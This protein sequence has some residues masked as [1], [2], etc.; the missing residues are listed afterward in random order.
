MSAAPNTVP[1]RYYDGRTPVPV[2]V[3][4]IWSGATVTL[5]GANI[6]QTYPVEGMRVSP[7]VGGADR[8]VALPDGAQL[9]CPDHPLLDRF[10]QEG[11]TEG[12]VAWLEQ[13]WQVALAGVVVMLA[14]LALGYFY[15]L[16]AAAERIAARVPV[17]YE[18]KL[19]EHALAWLDQHQL[20][21]PSRLEPST[22]QQLS[23]GFAELS[24]D[25][26]AAAHYRLLFRDAPAIGPNALAFPGGIIVITDEMIDLAESAGEVYA[27]LAHE[28]GHL[29]RR[30]TL[31]HILQNSITAAVAATLTAD[32]SSLTLAASGVP[33]MLV[34][35]KYSREF[36]TEADDFAFDLLKRHDLSP[37]H[38]ANL[39]ERLSA[40]PDA[41]FERRASFL[42]THPVTADR[43]ARA[44]AAAKN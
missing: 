2:P 38:F 5:M 33:V 8:F 24:R 13:R 40:K 14:G 3:T 32:A 18:K 19:G 27:V 11:R 41:Q 9:Q 29:Q 21:L 6:A 23:S 28:I 22:Q 30:H 39:M 1:A 26:P 16:P 12:V 31:R 36:E 15:G 43:I 17:E 37:E 10:P 35:A 4:V 44:R 20:F 7:R 42:S 34:Q 25:L